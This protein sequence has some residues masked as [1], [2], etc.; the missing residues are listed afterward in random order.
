M[1]PQRSAI[2]LVEMLVV[3][4]IIGIAVSLTLVAV[5]SSRE[6]A[7]RLAC[8]NNLHQIGIA[9][10][11]FAQSNRKFPSLLGNRGTTGDS[12][13]DQT[14]FVT[15]L[16]E[17]EV[18]AQ[19]N[20]LYV[21]NDSPKN[22]PPPVLRCPSSNQ[23]LGYRYC[24]GSGLRTLEDWDG[25]LRIYKGLTTSEITDGLSNTA[26]MSEHMSGKE[27]KKPIGMASL[28]TYMTDQAFA[29]DC[30]HLTSPSGFVVDVGLDW[31]KHQPRD[32]VYGH[33]ATPNSIHWEF[34]IPELPADLW[35]ATCHYTL[36]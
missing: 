14:P 7:R 6:S 15:I 34:D 9:L 21:A 26:I 32:L 5:Q 28:P 2:T 23:F 19:K 4:G 12:A 30:E 31:Q 25:I 3:I 33:Y 20:D 1:R 35:K 17:L 24:F 10:T 29:K 16:P 27:H 18:P 22:F 36:Q 11:N 8:Q 13:F